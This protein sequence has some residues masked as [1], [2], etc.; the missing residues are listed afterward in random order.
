MDTAVAWA[1]YRGPSLLESFLRTLQQAM[2]PTLLFN[3][4]PT[5]I[6]K[7]VQTSLH[8][9]MAIM[10][11]DINHIR[12][13]TVLYVPN[14]LTARDRAHV[15]NDREVVQRYEATVIHWTRQIRAVI[16]EQG[17]NAA[18]E[19]GGPLDEINYWRSRSRDLDNIRLQL[20]RSDVSAI[21][22]VLREAKSFYYLEPFLNLQADIER[23]TVEAFDNLCFLSTLIEPCERLAAAR[24]KE[25]PGLIG[26]ILV[27]AQFI[28]MHSKH[29][30]KERFCHLLRM[31]SDEIIRRCSV[32]IDIAAILRGDV[33]QSM[34]ALQESISAGEAWMKECRKMLSATKLRFKHEKGEK[35]D[36]DESSL[37]NEID[38]FISHRCQNLKE[39]CQGQMQFGFRSVG[40]SPPAS[41]RQRRRST[42][43]A[44]I[45]YPPREDP[46]G[47]TALQLPELNGTAAEL[48]AMFEGR[49]PIFS[50]NKGPEIE[51]QLMD[52]QR[53]FKSKIDMLRGL[54]YDILDVKSTKWIDDFGILKTDMDSLSMVMRQI[55]TA[56]FDSI[57]T[58][59]TGAE[60]IEAFYV[61]SRNEELLLQLDRS[62]DLVFRLF[63]SNLKTVQGEIQRYFNR[64]PTL[65]YLHPPA[66]GYAYWAMNNIASITQGYEELCRCYYLPESPESQ[67][68]MDLY[69]RL[70]RSLK[71]TVRKYYLDW[72]DS[73]PLKPAEYLDMYLLVRRH[74]TGKGPED[75]P[76]FEVNFPKQLLLLFDEVR[77]WQRL[78]EA[79]PAHVQ[80][81]CS[82]EERLRICR[83]NIALVTRAYNNVIM[84]LGSR[85]ELRLFT[86]RLRFLESKYQPGLTKLWWNSPGIVE[87][88]VRECR[89]QTER[90][91]SIVD[92]YKHTL[93]FVDHYCRAIADTL[94]VSFERKKTST[95]SVFVERQKRYRSSVRTRL[96]AIFGCIVDRLYSLFHYFRED[97]MHDEVVRSEWHHLM[98]NVE[99]KLEE[100]LK[101]MV[102]RS[103][104]TVERTLPAEVSEDRLCDKVFRLD[105][106]ISVAEDVNKPVIRAMPS[107]EEV[108]K[109][110]NEVCKQI[111]ST[112]RDLPH[113]DDSLSMRI[114]SE[115]DEELAEMNCP[116]V[117]YRGHTAEDIDLRGS[118]FECMA[119]DEDIILSLQRIQTAFVA[120]GE[121]VRDKLAQIWRLHQSLSTDN[122]WAT[123]KQDKRIKQGWKLEDYRINMDNVMHRRD[124][125]DKQEPFAEVQFL[126]LDFNKMKETFRKQCQLVIKHYHGLLY[127]DAKQELEAL[128]RVFQTTIESLTR[129]PKTLDQLG[130]QV[131][132][133]AEAIDN[134]PAISARFEPLRDRFALITSEA[135][136][137]GGVDA[138]DVARCEALPEVFEDY[139]ER[140]NAVRRQLD[141]YKE[142]FKHDLETDLRGLISSSFA[143]YQQ[144]REEAPTR[145]GMATT[146]AFAQLAVMA[147]RAEALRQTEQDLQHGIEIFNLTKPTLEDLTHAEEQL[148]VL[149][150]LWGLVEKWQRRRHEW[151]HMYFMKLNSDLMLEGL[152]KIRREVLRLRKDLEQ[153]DVWV[154]LKD[155]IDL[156]KKI[157]P[158]IDDMRT[159]AMRQRH[160]E[161]IKMQLDIE[162]DIH[163]E[164]FCLQCLMDARVET[165]AEFISNLA[166]A[167]RE[168]LKIETDLDKIHAFWEAADFTIEPHQGYNRITHVDE[169]NNALAEH[170]ALLTSSKM[171]RFVENFRGRVMQWEQTLSIVTDTIEG[172]LDVQT[173][174]MYLENIFIGSEDIK[175]KLVAEAKK[176]DSIHAQWL[177]IMSRL[178]KDPNVVRGTRRDT[179]LDQLNTMSAELEGIQKS[180]EWFLED[181]RRVFPRFYFLSNDDLLEILGHVKEPSKVQ[182]H[183]RKCFEGLYQLA[184]KQVRS[185]TIV[186]GMSSADGEY[187]S[188]GA[189]MHIEGLPVEAW[190]RSVEAKMRETMQL[191][192]NRTLDDLQRNV[193]DPRHPINR[194][195]LKGWVERNEGQCLI[196][197]ASINWTQQVEGAILEYGELHANGGLSLAR[198]KLSP[199][200]RIYK[201]WKGMIRKYCQMVRQ[202]Q[203]R[204]Q[205]SKLVALVTIE[206][207]ARDV[208][209]HILARRVHQLDD[210]EWSRQLRFYSE[211]TASEAAGLLPAT[212]GPAPSS[213]TVAIPTGGG[214]GGGSS[215]AGGGGGGGAGGGGGSGGAGG[216]VPALGTSN[217]TNSGSANAAGEALSA[218]I[219]RAT[220][221][222]CVV[223]QTSAVVRYD[224]EYLGNSGRLVVT[225][226]TDR[227][228]MMLTTALQLFRGGL[229]Q[230]PAGT[231]KTETVKDLGKAI[232]KYVMVFNCSESLDYRSVGRMLSG[233]AQTGAWSCF[234]EFNRI[235]VEVLSVVAQQILSILTA[236]S[237]R[238]REFLFEGTEIP[239]NLN[240]G[241]FV[242]M[243]PGY[244]GRSELP[245]NLKALLRPISMMVPDFG[246]I[247]EI[248]MLSEGFE[249][250]EVLSKKVSILYELMENQLSKQD[251]YDF[252]LRNIKAVLVQA[253]NLK[254]ENFPGTE[255]Q[256][257]LKAMKD[258][259][260]PKFVKE[261]VPLFLAMLR[262][263]FP[264]V[265][266]QGS[267]LEELWAAAIDELEA[268]NLEKNEHI[269]TKCLHLWDT[270]R[271]RHGVMVV[272]RSG[273]GKTVTWRTLAGAL[274][275][276][277]ECGVGGPYEPVRVSLLNP[278]SVTMDELYGSYNQATREW[279]DGILSDLM[280]QICRDATDTNYKWLLFDGPVD[281]LWIESMNTVL[282]DNK[283]LTLNSGERI[284]L[285]PTV[286]MLFEVQDLSQA[287]PATVS[288]CGMVYFTVEDLGWKPFVMTWLRSR[289]DFEIALN[290]PK[291]DATIHELQDFILNTLA[292]TL[293]FK[294]AECADLMPTTTLNTVR[295]FTTMFDALANSEARPVIPGGVSYQTS[296]AGE[297][298]LP[299]LRMAAMFC[300]VWAVGGPL[301][302]QSRRKLDSFVR[303]MDAS[304]PST[305]TVFE[306]FPEFHSLRWC[307]WEE[308][309]DLRRMYVPPPGAPYHKQIIPTIDTIRYEYLVSQ[310]VRSRVHLV[311]VGTAGTGKSLIARQVM[312]GLSRETHVT[313]EL[314]LSARTSARNVQDIIEGRMEHQSKKVC[315][316]PRGR[317]M[318]CLIEDLN[319]P[320]KE[321]F[322][323]QPPLEL[324]RQWLDNGFW[325]DAQT[326]A[327]RKVN[328]MQLLCCM[329]YGRPDISE[330]FMSK[331]NVFNITFPSET[332]IGKIFSAILENRMAPFADL[333]TYVS[334]IVKAT[335]ETYMKVSTELLPIP[336]KSHYLFSLRDLSK[337]FQ[338]IYG[339]HL[340]SL[341]CKEHLAGLWLHECERVFADRMN[342]EAD[343][344]WF[345]QVLNEKLNNDFQTKW[346]N[347]LK[348][349][350]KEGGGGGGGKG[351]GGGG[352][353]HP[354]SPQLHPQQPVTENESPIF[355]DFW[356][357]EYDEMAKYRL[358]PSMEALRQRVEENMERFNAEPGA[359]P[360]NLVFFNDA[361]RHL[362]RIH[363]IIR[364]PHGNALLVGLGGSG[365]SSLTRLAAYLA[366][367]TFFTIEVHKKYDIECFHEDLRTLY[368]ACGVKRQNKVFYFSDNQ[369]M[370]VS[371]LEDINNML[372]SGEVPNLFVKDDLRQIRDDVRKL[373]L[374]D[375][376]RDAPDELYNYFVEKARQHLHLV[377]AMSPAKKEFRDW[378]RQFP[379]LVSCTCIDWFSAWPTEALKE[380]GMRYLKETAESDET[381]EM[382]NTICDMF[383]YMH[384]TTGERSQQMR[385]H[386]HRY[387]YVTPSSYLDL[388]RGFRTMLT[389]KCEDIT[390]QR[391]K[392]ANG[393]S[394]LE[395]TKLTV[396][397]MTESLKVQDAKLQEKS[398]EV[399][400]ATESIQ[401]RQRIAEEQQTL[402]ASEKVKIEQAKRAALADQT[403]AQADLD[404]AMPTLLEA[405]A[406]L[407]KLDK[408]DINEVKSYKTPAAMVHTVMEAVQTALHRKLDWDEAKKSLSEP[409]FIDMLKT[410]HETHDM[411]DQKLLNSLEK[412]V[413]RHDF[414]P[415]AASSV[416]KAAGGLCQWVIAIHKYGNIYKEVHPKIVKNENAQQRV[417]AQE[418]MLRQKE[419]K[420]QRIMDEVRR[421]EA[422]L[423][424]NINEK[425]QLMRE[426][427]ETQDKLSRACIIVDGLEGERDRWTESI[428]RYEID[429]GNIRGDTLLA[430]GF[431]CYCGA[432]T[433]DYRHLLWQSWL[434]EM[435]RLQLHTNRDF[436]F[437][438]FL[439][440]PTEVRDWH[441]TGLPGDDF[442]RENGAIAMCGPRYP[443]MIDPQQQAIKW[444][445][446]MERDNGLKVIDPKQPDFQKTVENAVLLGCP[447]LLQDVLEEIDPILDPIMSRTI[448]RKG[449]RQLVKLGDNYIEYNESFK[450][451]ITTRLS[452]PHYSP[453]TCTK[454]CLLNFAVKE[455]GLEEQLLKIVVEREKPELEHENE[456][457]ILDMAAAKKET[458]RL[459]DDILD[460]LSSFQ[461]SLLE[462]KRLIDT[463][464]SAKVTAA[465]IKK[466][467]KESEETS[468]KISQAREEYRE[469][470]QRASILFFVLADLGAID[471][472]YQFALDSYIELFQHS[473]RRS[474]EK[475]TSRSM[476]ERIK[477]LNAWH[478]AAVYT[479]TCRGLFERHKLLFAFHMTMRILQAAGRVNLEEYAFLMRGGQIL[480]KQGRLPNPAPSWLSERC[481]DHLL[482]LDKLTNFHGIAA[483]VEQ[484]ADLW[485]EWYLLELP[486]E[487]ELPGEWQNLCRENYIQK[488]IFVRCL[489]PDRLVFMVYEFIEDQLGAQF[490]EP[491]TFNLKEAYEESS[492]AIP[493]VFV[494]SAGVDPTTQLNAIAQRGG[495]TLKTLALGQGQGENAKRA[496]QELSQT[497]GWVFLANCHLMV[498][499]LVELEKIIDDLAEQNPH[500][501]F[502]L[503][504]S[505]VPT[506]G[507]PIGILQRAIK[508][509]TEPPKGIKGN[510]LRLYNGMSEE[511]FAERSSA[512]PVFYRNL[513]FALCFF[514][515]VLL[516]RRKYGTLGYNVI[517]DFTASDFEVSENILDLYL[518]QMHSDLAEDIPFVTIRYLIAEASYGGRVTDDWDRRVLNTYMEQYFCL[519]AVT[520]EAYPLSAAAEYVI[521]AECTTVQAYL[522]ECAHLPITDPAEAFGQHANADIASRIAESTALLDNLISINATLARGSAGGSGLTTAANSTTAGAT[523][524]PSQEDRCL[525]ILA[526]L[527]ESSKAAIPPLIDYDAIFEATSEERQNALNTCLLQEVQRYNLLLAKIH[528]QCAALRLAV[529]GR[530]VMSDELEAI[531]AALLLGRTPPPWASAY[532]SRKPLASWSVD[533]VARVE[534]LKLWGQRT[535]AV[536]WLS[537]LTYPTGFLKSLQQQ[538]ARADH[539]SIDQYGWEF[540]L[541]AQEERG[542]IHGPKKGAYV[543]GIYLEGA[544][545][546]SENNTLCE[547]NPMELIVRMPV[548]HFIPKL[549][550]P[551]STPSESNVYKA[552][553]YMYPIR[554]GTRE[555]PSFVVAVDLDSGEAAP[556][557]YTKRGTAL[558]LSTDE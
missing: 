203:S 386:L 101:T 186:E 280:R 17:A 111:I 95:L 455:Q 448:I 8:R 349:R 70:V 128:Y 75:P 173:K 287:S 246:L 136:N 468:V 219:V 336:S 370:H 368:K 408:S 457:L 291:P 484:N 405:Q 330:R 315:G 125:M 416:S 62:K 342:N 556:Q 148:A 301:T 137:F 508:M 461:C 446:R 519:R 49:L 397:R 96:K 47:K 140:F 212:P 426:A 316:P 411:T 535:P 108:S 80:D 247:C 168:E 214:G 131:R 501:E 499:W 152:E 333:R 258:M 380:I 507:F 283:M 319:M 226:L 195:K 480:D 185:G 170:L 476:D 432:F 24:L 320:A 87:Y 83:E 31:V 182:P 503:W 554:T 334:A 5:S 218:G 176:F 322:G 459:E 436:N 61:L 58:I 391:D 443:L 488:M 550:P 305:E 528:R 91:Q 151:M 209:R 225:G 479:N 356:D 50:G 244:A 400:K 412:Y 389:K 23:G 187:V 355:V 46:N 139:I 450:L 109:R 486:E 404:R 165:Q 69:D 174:W 549:I 369:V 184:L 237:E 403:E 536:F 242:T 453:E 409:K 424:T 93:I 115:N 124:D 6:E 518:R 42:T 286:S 141:I 529:R 396:S 392:L 491:P 252:S 337:V 159:P 245:D 161:F 506:P 288:R 525:E 504:L 119:G 48:E 339:C 201:K 522:Q 268:A 325:Y 76:L 135:Y 44:S 516:E 540:A 1:C 181:R 64:K 439:V 175:R 354:S 294:A 375:G 223:R 59:T 251:H 350:V 541:L 166:V 232:G 234:D 118:Y 511:Q 134:L 413:K 466:Q 365:R 433:A 56:A 220:P 340:A 228:Y 249:E 548:I 89:T 463:L 216:G 197:A 494:L 292:S 55:I 467:L 557:H 296:Q 154:R 376:C 16:G 67:E 178:V 202:P 460:L 406:A 210:F 414:T 344:A 248:T 30:R 428:A 106:I 273:S 482:E 473:I 388:V 492:N 520:E 132:S 445:K 367:Y 2:M 257:C 345:H 162:F 469:C 384:D 475:I 338:G 495:H 542:I 393:M 113:I 465:N 86:L 279:K 199:L 517:Y 278:K 12:G 526:S 505:S 230:G 84:S 236:V 66:A 451:Y 43:R 515:S 270:L 295:S 241:L 555:R 227:A 263:L 493:L 20:N 274:K 310:L 54:D 297:N 395:E 489:R 534:Q 299:Q 68:A 312:A 123:E 99:L 65:F 192:I 512:H 169:L 189:P 418:E 21:V 277:A 240:C 39:I 253:G 544:G 183:L 127:A 538:Q 27:K 179:L 358:V 53:A 172:L 407:D 357:G 149:R 290:T 224:Y 481:W 497:G 133:C 29:Y 421:L 487:A 188:F 198:R 269:L 314:N 359:R 190:L 527:S 361:L 456:K 427:R 532:P 323:A 112:V 435:R 103:L 477:T 63:M 417:R 138:A 129:E 239:L 478:T 144:V 122:L 60:Y 483:H 196:T 496:I 38:G 539:V 373:A 146:E 117:T 551:N 422:D 88:Y 545:W 32:R 276:L 442:S 440:D 399:S 472:M 308:H 553:L 204:M 163:S 464:Q 410:Y 438:N 293:A 454:V 77:Y 458:K 382:L 530:I 222:A 243:N 543:R 275:R 26:D 558:L 415:A 332:V 490:V 52:I 217:S 120:V 298:Y 289:R 98:E 261:D 437:V 180:L 341:T 474:A 191:G 387:N 74:S 94:S 255:S 385:E 260:L 430:T 372:S 13:R 309:P 100:A 235:E 329:T 34:V 335:I 304:F 300:L 485:R 363:R 431:M 145:W 513:L 85:E 104:L 328:D 524:P 107:V 205:R 447:L 142:Q 215:A 364:L 470:A 92:D 523:R 452:N 41:S 362:C 158:I 4:W 164:E 71:D 200:Y 155:D 379:A 82:K 347:I 264:G 552:P 302:V 533:L 419:E 78:G 306:Y 471:S 434:K 423:N 37:L 143:L 206:V 153:L 130:E 14:D 15:H 282:D 10:V 7:D 285:N 378:L 401:V 11:E 114:A 366:G 208:L 441:Q 351:V 398:E 547:P 250:S 147:R 271:T 265:E 429:L 25:I 537:G 167:A 272:G 531:F 97:Y 254:R 449:N 281:T 126:L 102:K 348:S 267:G 262:D 256:L 444:I 36:I 233:I 211:E 90:V 498:S 57:A 40:T 194:E 259:N 374:V 509:T 371:F 150:T 402:V 221:R 33:A 177:S 514:H 390:E 105:V 331:L 307:A 425:N 157:L 110:I 116:F 381:D 51:S 394:K 317:R 160:W 18:V 81:I 22:S 343:R 311:L 500:K 171:S 462:N 521:P 35:L 327:Q 213:T 9:F 420:L 321:K 266:P 28:L 229:P 352:L 313:T 72:R 3:R 324:L 303:E 238:R 383:V 79:I 156:L 326:R 207:H 193:Y 45:P 19:D 377:V 121:K 502:R 284:N 318:I 346:V 73:L 360:V 353:G 231:G 546:N 510:M